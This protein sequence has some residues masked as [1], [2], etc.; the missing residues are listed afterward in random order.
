MDAT[1]MSLRGRAPDRGRLYQ[2][3]QAQPRHRLSRTVGAVRG[4]PRP[5][6]PRP[7]EERREAAAAPGIAVPVI[8]AVQQ[9]TRLAQMNRPPGKAV[10]TAVEAL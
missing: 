5:A 6:P 1:F 7:A 8:P 2:G 9:V 3:H 4:R 10:T